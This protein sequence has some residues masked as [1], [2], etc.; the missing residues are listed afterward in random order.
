M[1]ENFDLTGKCALVTGGSGGI[2]LGI[3]RGLADAG[4]AVCI[5][6][7]DEARCQRALQQL[8]DQG[9]KA[10]ALTSDV[11]REDSVS[12]LV[13]QCVEASGRLDIVVNCAGINVR[14]LPQDMSI[15]EWDDVLRTNLTSIF[16]TS[17]A[18]YPHLV[19]AGGGK[20]INVGSLGSFFA[21]A[22]AAPYVAAKGG[23]VQLTKCL[24]VA[25]AKDNIQVNCFHPGYTDTPFMRKAREEVPTMNDKVLSRTALGRWATPE[26]FQGLVQFLASPASNY[27]T[28]ASIFA[29]GGFSCT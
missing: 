13:Q 28:G 14:K 3:A 21:A 26:D 22:Y 9:A 2:G 8:Q 19:A 4:A 18:A 20:I 1:L 25:W 27:I 6:S 17:R 11:R 16:I 15:D 23:L 24:A 29:D 12:S 5:T 7:R 10:I